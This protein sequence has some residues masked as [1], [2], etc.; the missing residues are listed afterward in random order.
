ML[1]QRLKEWLGNDGISLFRDYKKE[2]GTVSPVISTTHPMNPSGPYIPHPVHFREGMQVRNW[3][4]GQPECAGWSDHDYD[5]RWAKLVNE[6]I[7]DG[8]DFLQI[9]K[10]VVE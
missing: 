7:A 8:V 1:I 4:R 6:A 2:F 3:L 5:D 10:E 9:T